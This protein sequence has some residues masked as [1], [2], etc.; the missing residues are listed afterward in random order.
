MP[1]EFPDNIY[2]FRNRTIFL[3]SSNMVDLTGL[4]TKDF[5]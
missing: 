4:T 1:N 3:P 5:A 2:T